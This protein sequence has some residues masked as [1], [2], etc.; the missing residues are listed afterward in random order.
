MQVIALNTPLI[1]LY[2]IPLCSHSRKTPS[3]LCSGQVWPAIICCIFLDQRLFFI[4]Q[5]FQFHPQH[6]FPILSVSVAT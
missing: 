4:T 2:W 3:F 5:S 1:N 6:H